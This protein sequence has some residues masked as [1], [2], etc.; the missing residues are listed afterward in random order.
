MVAEAPWS[1]YSGRG[2]Y[3]AYRSSACLAPVMMNAC[4]PSPIDATFFHRRARFRAA[5]DAPASSD[6]DA[7]VH[8]V[9]AE[10]PVPVVGMTMTTRCTG[11]GTTDRPVT[12][13]RTSLSLAPSHLPTFH[14]TCHTPA[15]MP[16]LPT[17][18][19]PTSLD[20]LKELLKDDV[21]VKVAGGS[22][23]EPVG[24]RG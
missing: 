1:T 4:L 18:N 8:R 14:P 10:M 21:K 19:A 3:R 24:C 7:L 9:K 2:V 17:R 13:N 22:T 12:E 6:V 20:E 15:K 11:R 23:M 16:L 5:A